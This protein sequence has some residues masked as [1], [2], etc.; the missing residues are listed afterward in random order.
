[1]SESISLSQEQIVMGNISK[2]LQ[3]YDIK[4]YPPE[5]GLVDKVALYIY[6]KEE[7]GGGQKYARRSVYFAELP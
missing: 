2:H 5:K 1:M 3:V 7:E 6:L 4:Y